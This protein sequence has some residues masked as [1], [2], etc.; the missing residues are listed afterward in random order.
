MGGGGGGGGGEQND[1]GN[2]TLLAIV[3]LHAFSPQE[4]IEL[5]KV[6]NA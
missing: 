6:G 4:K 3:C 2:Y 5:V 1:E